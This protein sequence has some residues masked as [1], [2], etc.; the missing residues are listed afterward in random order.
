MIETEPTTQMFER[1]LPQHLVTKLDRAAKAGLEQAATPG[2]VVGVR[3]PEGTWTKAYGFADPAN[4]RRM[5]V[6]IHTRVGS[7]TKT[8]TGTLLLQLD[9][10]GRL[11]LDDPISKYVA[12]VPNGDEVT[13]RHLANMTSGVA[14]YTANAAFVDRLFANPRASFD[15]DELIAIGLADSPMFAPGAMFYYSNTNFLLLGKVIEKVTGDRLGQVYR[16]RI[17]RPLGLDDTSWPGTSTA[18]PG[19]YAKG[20]TLQGDT[21]TPSRP[22]NA[23]HWNPS[24]GGA[25]GAIISNMPDLLTYGRALGTGQGLLRP[26]AQAERL[27]SFPG[28]SGYG[29]AM[30]CVDGWVGHTGELPGYNTTLFYDTTTDTTVVVQANSDI[31]SGDCP[32]SP[33]LADDPRRIVCSAPATRIFVALSKALGHTFTPPPMS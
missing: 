18:L 27:Q 12:G 32:Q 1:A 5:K 3:S 13:L 16:Q 15:A 11:S 6:G 30:G 23:T 20:F 7:V 22:A 14:S 9:Q 25:A 4:L 17:F 31:A 28:S 33:T 19:P 10:E 24:W 26:G 21:A 2:A 29:L 8:F